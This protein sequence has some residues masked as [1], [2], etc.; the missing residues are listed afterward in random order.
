[1][2]LKRLLPFGGVMILLAGAMVLT[3]PARADDDEGEG[4]ASR[5]QQGFKIA[6][7]TLNYKGKNHALVGYGS[8]LV[9]AVADCN[10]CH[11]KDP[12]SEYSVNPYFIQK[13]FQKVVNPDYYLGGGQD[14][15]PLPAAGFADIVTRNITPDKT[16][17]PAGLSFRDFL[18]V[19][20]KGTDMDKWHPTCSGPPNGHCVPAPFDGSLLQIMPWPAFQDMTDGDL[21]A[22]YEY[23]SAIPCLEGDPGNP[24]GSNTNGKRCH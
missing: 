9:N 14:F 8:Y 2:I 20:R 1:M 22:I 18:D 21:R 3:V 11:T 16:G 7:V 12:Q 13:N 17:R 24:A 4:K 10:G 15:G 19:I 6:P 5:V 23:L